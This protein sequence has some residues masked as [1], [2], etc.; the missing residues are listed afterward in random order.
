MGMTRNSVGKMM[1]INDSPAT[2]IDQTVDLELHDM[3]HGGRALGRH[4]GM[5]VFVPFG[6]PGERVLARIYHKHKRYAEAEII[7]IITPSQDRVIPKCPYFGVCGGCHYQHIRYDRQLEIKRH[8]VESLLSR[9]GGFRDIKVL[10][11]IPSPREYYYRN[12]ARF[13]C[14]QQGDL[15]FT[16]WR[17]NSFIKVDTCPIMDEKINEVLQHIQGHGLPGENVRVRYSRQKDELVIWPKLSADLETGQQFHTQV[18]LGREFRVSAT[19]FFQ[20]NTLQAE[21]LIRIALDELEPLEGKTVVDAYCGVGTFTRFIAE[22]A[23]LTIGIEESPSATADFR[24]NMQ[25]LKAKLIEGRAEKELGRLPN[26]I[27]R[28]L[29]DPP[30]TG[31]E[32]EALETILELAPEK[33]VY[34][35]CDPATLARDLKVLCSTGAYRLKKVQPVDMFPQTFHIETIASLELL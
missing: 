14:G 15:G 9:I 19:S 23:E 33:I 10:P 29:L 5:V 7:D 18:L 1:G 22:R 24:Y 12:S 6:I 25:G 28:L 16:D 3:A 8:I 31:C 13:L 32:P 17:S 34:V 21:N 2:S 11:T 30:R 4:E 27:D 26:N 35:S 20:V